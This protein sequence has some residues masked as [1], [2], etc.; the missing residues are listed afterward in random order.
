LLNHKQFLNQNKLKRDKSQ[1]DY[2]ME[3]LKQ[4]V[5][6]YSKKSAVKARFSTKKAPEKKAVS[7]ASA[8]VATTTVSNK[9][10]AQSDTDNG[11]DKMVS[12]VL[13]LFPDMQKDFIKVCKLKYEIFLKILLKLKNL[14]F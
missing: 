5:L 7:S 3:N 13:D 12:S 11:V 1:Y 2:I 9:S 4:S 10:S 6:Q 8:H 14:F